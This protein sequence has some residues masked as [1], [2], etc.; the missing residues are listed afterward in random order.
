MRITSYVLCAA[1]V[2]ALIAAGVIL[3]LT[4]QVCVWLAAAFMYALT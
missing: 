1:S 4:L 3:L 2:V